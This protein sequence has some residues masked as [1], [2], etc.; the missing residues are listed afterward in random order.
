MIENPIVDGAKLAPRDVQRT[1]DRIGDPDVTTPMVNERHCRFWMAAPDSDGYGRLYIQKKTRKA[2]RLVHA[3]YKGDPGEF[4]VVRH[5]C[6]N[7]MCVEEAHIEGGTHKQNKEDSMR[8]GTHTKGI[9]INTAKLTERQAAQCIAL[10]DEGA[11]VKLIA[12]KFG[13]TESTIHRVLNGTT[14]R[15]LGGKR[16]APRPASKIT[17]EQA[18][19]CIENRDKMLQSEIARVLGISQQHVSDIQRGKK[20][21]KAA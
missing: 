2:H 11:S 15:H 1:L 17:D 14:W 9:Q 21:K 18:K 12:R 13:V 5:A 10:D 19:F 4:E 8:A 7:R 20:R 16:R 3:I 6:N